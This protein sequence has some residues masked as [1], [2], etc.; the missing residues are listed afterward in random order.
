M[1]NKGTSRQCLHCKDFFSPS[2][3]NAHVQQFCRLNDECRKAASRASSKKCREKKRNDLSWKKSE[4][5]RIK[6]WQQKH[7]D[8][9]KKEKKSKIMFSDT[10][11]RDFAQAQKIDSLPLLRDF[12]LYYSACLTGF[13]AHTTDQSGN[14]LLRDNAFSYLNKF[15]DKGIALST[16][17]TNHSFKEEDYHDSKGNRKAGVREAHA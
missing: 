11:L 3:Y 6:S 7:P 16:E 12:V 13:I 9:W 5:E 14:S 4:C 17:R 2:N 8:Y 10:L 15:Y 1:K